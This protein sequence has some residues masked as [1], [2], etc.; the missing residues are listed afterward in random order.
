[1]KENLL[2]NKNLTLRKTTLIAQVLNLNKVCSQIKKDKR[3]ILGNILKISSLINRK[4]IDWYLWQYLTDKNKKALGAEQAD[5]Y[6]HLLREYR[7]VVGEGI[8]CQANYTLQQTLRLLQTEEEK[9][10]KET[11]ESILDKYSAVKEVVVISKKD[12]ITIIEKAINILEE[13][14]KNSPCNSRKNSYST[15]NTIYK[16]TTAL[17]GINK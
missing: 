10:T 7:I 17:Q 2:K 12:K 14:F 3:E 4:G 6:M 1:M 15:K 9:E 8:N 5:A 16:Y 13:V 11:L